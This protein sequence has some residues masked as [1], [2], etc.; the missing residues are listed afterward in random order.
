MV[1][2]VRTGFLRRRAPVIGSNTSAAQRLG[3]GTGELNG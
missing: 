1:V 2:R 3:G